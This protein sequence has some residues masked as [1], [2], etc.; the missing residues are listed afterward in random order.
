[1]VAQRS[2]ENSGMSLSELASFLS[3]LGVVK[4]MN[5]DG[6]SSSALSYQGQI[7]YGRLDREGNEVKR[8]LKSVLLVTKKDKKLDLENGQGIN[9]IKW[10]L[11]A[12]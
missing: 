12:G 8:P 9:F 7:V 6:G 5:L 1:M 3:K 2:H 4:A 10:D 11:S